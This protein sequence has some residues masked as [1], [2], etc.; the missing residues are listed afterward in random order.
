MK[1]SFSN[2]SANVRLCL[3]LCADG[4]HA[5]SLTSWRVS[6]RG[7]TNTKPF[8]RLVRVGAQVEY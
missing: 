1:M 8:D 3:E 2:D 5:G 7:T 6:V 4:N